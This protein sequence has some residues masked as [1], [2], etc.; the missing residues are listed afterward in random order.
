MAPLFGCGLPLSLPCLFHS[1]SS[2]LLLLLLY[3]ASEPAKKKIDALEW[4]RVKEETDR[5][6][7]LAYEHDMLT[8]FPMMQLIPER[9]CVVI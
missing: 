7:I 1:I 4:E 6:D 2:D 8:K 3:L 5:K 9:K